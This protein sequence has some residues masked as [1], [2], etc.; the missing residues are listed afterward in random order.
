MTDSSSEEGME[1]AGVNEAAGQSLPM[2]DAG[3][4]R[5]QETTKTRDRNRVLRPGVACFAERQFLRTDL[6]E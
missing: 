4:V 2:P 5:K 1:K 3:E 6:W